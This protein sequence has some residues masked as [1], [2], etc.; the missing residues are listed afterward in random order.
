MPEF[1]IAAFANGF[2]SHGQQNHGDDEYSG[3]NEK[4][5]ESHVFHLGKL[6]QTQL[7]VQLVGAI[8]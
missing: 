5:M 7:D 4:W 8:S 6:V 2:A 3:G 1:D